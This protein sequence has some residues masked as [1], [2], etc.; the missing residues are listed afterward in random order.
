MLTLP[1]LASLR[2]PQG[3]AARAV[4]F[5]TLLV[6]ATAA[7]SAAIVLIGAHRE[8]ERQELAITHDLTE[9]FAARAGDV[10]ARG[11]TRVLS[12]MIQGT[13]QRNSVRAL[14]VRD[15]QNQI[16]AQEGGDARDNATMTRLAQRAMAE[17]RSAYERLQDGGLAVAS[18][19]VREG[20][21]LGAAVRVSS[22]CPITGTEVRVT[23]TSDGVEAVEP[24]TAVMSM[25]PPDLA[26]FD[27][28]ITTL[29]HFIW[30][31]ADDGAA[32]SWTAENPDTFVV[33]IEDGFEIGRRMTDAVFDVVL[34][35]RS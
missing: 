25:M 23:V 30:F 11:N 21:V 3:L 14:S 17:R 32:R 26:S 28:I 18:P 7:I 6:A 34:A 22:H 33:S 13:V 31:F 12:Y 19:I 1:R 20:H 29:C 16:L 4:L 27:D 9:H 10:M 2:R 35:E 15:A 5:T 8:G 24:A